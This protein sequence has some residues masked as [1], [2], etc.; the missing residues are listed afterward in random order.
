MKGSKNNMYNE[1]IANLEKQLTSN[2]INKIKNQQ[3]HLSIFADPYLT[4]MY[5]ETEF[6]KVSMTCTPAWTKEQHKIIQ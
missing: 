3:I 5:W 2:E 1:I 6:C 4:Y